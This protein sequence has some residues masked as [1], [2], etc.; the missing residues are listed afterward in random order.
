MTDKFKWYHTDDHA[1]PTL[2][3]A[4]LGEFMF[5][6]LSVGG[7]IGEVWPF[8]PRYPRSSVYFTVQLTEQ[9]KETLE[10]K[11]KRVKFKNPPKINLNS[12]DF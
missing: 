7:K 2:T 1:T 10:T 11:F 4:S 8:N 12:V 3:K 5:E 9:M 6:V